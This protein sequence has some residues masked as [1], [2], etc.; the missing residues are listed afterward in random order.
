MPGNAF[1]GPRDASLGEAGGNTENGA[2]QLR[3]LVRKEGLHL[4][5]SEVER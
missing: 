1:N 3:R 2:V 5:G 4:R